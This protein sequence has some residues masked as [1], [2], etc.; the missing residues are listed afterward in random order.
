MKTL[1]SVLASLRLPAFFSVFKMKLSKTIFVFFHIFCCLLCMSHALDTLIP[2]RIL[3][4]NE[5]L[6]SAGGVFE[7]GFFTASKSSG[8][9]FKNDRNKKPVWVANRD[10]AL[11]DST[12]VLSI[13]HDGKLVVTDRSAIQII[14]NNEIL[15]TINETSVKI[16]DSGNLV[17]MEE[18]KIIWQSFDYPT[19]T[20]PSGMNLVLFNM[21][22]GRLRKQFLISW[23]SLSN[24]NR[25]FYSLGLDSTDMTKFNVWCI[26]GAY[27]QIGFWDGL[28]FEFFFQ[29]LSGNHYNF[30]FIS[31]GRDIYLTFNNTKSNV[32]SWFVLTSDG[33]IS[34]F[35]MVGQNISRVNYSLCD[36]TLPC[37]TTGCL[38]LTPMMCKGGNSFPDIRGLIP[39]SM[40]V[41]WEGRLGCSNCELL[42]RSNCSC[43]A[44]SS[45][46]DDGTGCELTYGNKDDLLNNR[47]RGNNTIH[48]CADASKSG[49]PF[50]SF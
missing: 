20:C 33:A 11:V 2:G 28:V 48:V 30:S 25:G 46:L 18:G 23:L 4:S 40:A 35:R 29:H 7:L 9:W 14:V 50:S 1:S 47:G 45:L 39:N 13:R 41:T 8:I 42:C 37:N 24:P 3:H 5:T 32:L 38:V 34:E 19:D 43:V 17:L 27:Q 21:G 15:A 31:N 16:L 36:T 26:G 22:T 12:G 49:K 44:Y 6:I 10:D